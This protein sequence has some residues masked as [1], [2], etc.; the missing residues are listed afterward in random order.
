MII[1]SIL[2]LLL[3]LNIY[4][5]AKNRKKHQDRIKLLE[6]NLDAMSRVLYETSNQL[7]DQSISPIT[8]TEDDFQIVSSNLESAQ[9]RLAELDLIIQNIQ[10]KINKEIND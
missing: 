10:I 4:I 9:D 3:F 7:K 2:I 1:D 6:S 8:V 5:D